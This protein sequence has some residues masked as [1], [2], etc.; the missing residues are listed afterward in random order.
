MWH[1]RQLH[2]GVIFY[3]PGAMRGYDVVLFT[4]A[5]AITV[6][7]QEG[8]RRGPGLDAPLTT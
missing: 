7:R 2:S 8:G 4:V 1:C 5:L 3:T 6:I